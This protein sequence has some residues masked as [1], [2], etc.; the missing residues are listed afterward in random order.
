MTAFNF[1][2]PTRFDASV[3]DEGVWFGIHDENDN[4]WG[5][6]KCAMFDGD[7]RRIKLLQD[8][9]KKKYAKDI[10]TGKVDHDALAREVFLEA[11]LQDWRGVKAGGKDVPYSK[12]A[13]AAYFALPTTKYALTALLEYSQDVRNF[14]QADKEEVAKNS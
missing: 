1:D 14:Q 7:S 6:F 11:I 12:E 4:H 5:D 9:L 3:A 13:A 10:R 8:R 2:V